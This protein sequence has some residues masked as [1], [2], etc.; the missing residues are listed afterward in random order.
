[1]TLNLSELTVL[2]LKNMC[3]KKK[4][5]GYSSLVKND[6]IKLL[7]K[8]IKKGGQINIE[9]ATNINGKKYKIG[10]DY[11]SIGKINIENA[12]NINGKKYKIGDDYKS[13]EKINIENAIK[14]ING[15]K[16]K[17][18]DDYKSLGKIEDFLY[19]KI[20][21]GIKLKDGKRLCCTKLERHTFDFWKIYNEVKPRS[22]KLIGLANLNKLNIIKN[23]KTSKN[24]IT[25]AEYLIKKLNL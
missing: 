1:M 11:E 17:I 3:K 16:Y 24:K 12:I 4:I 5:K 25:E 14:N 13:L 8:H 22:N 2:E 7:K 10:D 20:P 9:N 15:K 23:D 6:L 18:G 21:I 19:I